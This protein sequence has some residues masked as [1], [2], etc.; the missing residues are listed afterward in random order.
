[1]S[2]Y[3]FNAFHTGPLTR[4]HME[5]FLRNPMFVGLRMPDIGKT[6]PLESKLPSA[7]ANALALLKITLN[8]D[9]EQRSTC[10][11]LM[12]HPYFTHDNFPEKFEQELHVAIS[13]ER[14]K[15]S[16]K[17]RR[18]KRA[19]VTPKRITD[20]VKAIVLVKHVAHASYPV[21]LLLY[22][23]KQPEREK[24][25]TYAVSENSR[26]WENKQ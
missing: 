18:K 2:R 11:Q 7:S 3:A 26:Y 13:S 19:S 9:P 16:A 14:D 12:E 5:N 1:M 24:E 25:D 22:H 15:D 17:L 8:Y 23:F 4:R 10:R 21:K 20:H 6:T